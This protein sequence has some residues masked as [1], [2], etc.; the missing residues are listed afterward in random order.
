MRQKQEKSVYLNTLK[1]EIMHRELLISFYNTSFWAIVEKYSGKVYNKRFLNTLN[2]ELQKK[3]I[4]LSAIVENQGRNMYSNYKENIIVTIVLCCRFDRFNYS[5][6]ERLYVNIVLDHGEMRINYEKSKGET[7][8][9]SWYDNFVK[10]T[11]ESKGIIKRYDK[12]LKTAEKIQSE[13]LKYKD[14]P[15]RFRKNIDFDGLYYLK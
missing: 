13:I 11:E 3:N 10:D 2:E 12:Y 4:L 14:L 8:T 6:K 15:Y 5:D 7:Y 1:T 9:I